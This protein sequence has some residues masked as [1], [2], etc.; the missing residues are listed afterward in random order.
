M[1]AS[2]YPAADCTYLLDVFDSRGAH[3]YSGTGNWG[4]A[5]S[6]C[7]ITFFG[8]AKALKVGVRPVQYTAIRTAHRDFTLKNGRLPLCA[9]GGPW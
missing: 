9:N 3:E 7:R 6:T 1:D 5:D 2:G 8:P 4:G